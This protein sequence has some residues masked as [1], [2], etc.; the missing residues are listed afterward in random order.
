MPTPGVGSE[1]DTVAE[2]RRHNLAQYPRWGRF[3][4]QTKSP[5]TGRASLQVLK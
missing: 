5:A 3:L 1:V 2:R 4:S